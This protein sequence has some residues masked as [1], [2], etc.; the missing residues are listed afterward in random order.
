MSLK[1][2]RVDFAATWAELKETVKGVVTLGNIPQAVWYNRFSDVYSLCVAY[3]EPLA[4]KLYQETKKFLEEH[5]KSLL[6][7]VNSTNEEQL[8]TVY[9][10]L[11]LQYSQGIDY[12]HKL[13]IYLN[14]QHI[15]KQKASDAEVL[16][17]ILPEPPEQMKEIGELGLDLWKKHMIEPLKDVLLRLLLEAIRCDRTGQSLYNE[18]SST[19]HGVIQVLVAVEEYKKK[20]NLELYE[21]VFETPFLE[22]T[23]EYYRQE[24]SRLLQECTISQYMEKVLQRRDEEDLRGRKFLHPNSYQKVR[25]VCEQ[26]MVAMHL[27]AIHNECPT[28]VQQELHQDLRNAFALLKPISGGLSVL[29]TQVMEHIKQQGLRA[30][31]NLSGDNVASQFVEGM[32]AVHA[33]YKEMVGVVFANDQLFTSALDMACASVVNHRLNPKQPCRSP[34]LLAKYCDSLLKKSTKGG[35]DSEVDEKLAQCIIVFKYID[36][37]DVFQKFYARMLAKRLIH[38]QSH[39]M[40]SEE[41]MINRLKQACGYEFTNKLHRMFTDMSVSSDL[42][43]KFNDYLQNKGRIELGLNFSIYV[44][45]A[46]AWPLGQNCPTDFAV[47]QELEKSV[48]RFEEFYHDQFNGRKLAWLHHL[49][50]GE[51]KLNYLK[52]PYIIT[53]Q[54]FQMAMLLM[55]ENVNSITCKELMEATKLNSDHFQKYVQSLVESKLLIV[56]SGTVEVFEPN[57][58][59]SLNM[60]YS[61][62]RT[63]F[64]ITAAVQR[65]TVQEA[66][67]THS[68]V[69]EDRKLYLQVTK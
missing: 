5:V 46:G 69:D 62:K 54:T 59:V 41:A 32:L 55:F 25:N 63:K 23:G 29:V 1:P 64:R 26:E 44:L 28:M 38:Q 15:K 6:A 56:S 37:K 36:D 24:A 10:N 51:L 27:P 65:E 12:L 45:Q 4:E 57:T 40:D 11:W 18:K 34:E 3:P 43:N 39:S 21:T 68:S 33:K 13:Y 61:N 66:E 67:Q 58:I 60:E 2:K 42:N 31:A 20:N 19:I 53:M 22:A 35:S 49:S 16:Y 47:P 7:Q 17:G 8:L 30:V 48:Q 52:K 9:Y 14:T 50:Q